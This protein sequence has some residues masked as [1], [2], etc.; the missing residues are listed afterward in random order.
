[1]LISVLPRME[2]TGIGDR[3]GET[4]AEDSN[5]L[6]PLKLDLILKYE[7][8]HIFL[9]SHEK[10]YLIC[11][12][13]LITSCLLLGGYSN[14]SPHNQD[15]TVYLCELALGLLPKSIVRAS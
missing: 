1:M 15:I 9:L 14:L 7:I 6:S 13:I 11:L 8:I 12:S 2:R 10:K 4:W 3:R 5:A